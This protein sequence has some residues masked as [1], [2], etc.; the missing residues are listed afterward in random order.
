MSSQWLT[1]NR[2]MLILYRR[3]YRA[4]VSFMFFLLFIA[5]LQLGVICY[6][7]FVKPIPRYYAVHD[8]GSLSAI[9][10]LTQP[11]FGSSAL[12]QWEK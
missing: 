11:N 2:N 9:Q 6:F 7:V 4:T 5:V 1:H 10:P 3:N 8:D 12:S